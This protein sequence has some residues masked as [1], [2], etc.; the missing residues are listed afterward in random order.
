MMLGSMYQG[1]VIGG[2]KFDT[3]LTF[4]NR[5][6]RRE[7]I[8]NKSLRV[9]ARRGSFYSDIDGFIGNYLFESGMEI[10]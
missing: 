2:I 1:D 8:W 4:A 7:N 10:L 5:Q 3:S 9:I 6:L